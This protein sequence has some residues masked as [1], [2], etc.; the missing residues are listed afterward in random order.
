MAGPAHGVKIYSL[1]KGS[2]IGGLIGSIPTTLAWPFVYERLIAANESIGSFGGD[3]VSIMADIMLS[4]LLALSPGDS[5][6]ILPLALIF[7]ATYFA[8]LL[9]VVGGFLVYIHARSGKFSLGYQLLVFIMVAEF[10]SSTPLLLMIPDP[11]TVWLL[12]GSSLF[13][14]IIGYWI[15]ANFALRDIVVSHT[16]WSPYRGKR[17]EGGSVPNDIHKTQQS[18][19][20]SDPN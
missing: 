7:S 13:G 8:I 2:V 5:W 19:I 6:S 11:A 20:T 14:D 1:L 12:V 9:S 17:K 16:K 3:E 4:L 15:F 18:P 10:V